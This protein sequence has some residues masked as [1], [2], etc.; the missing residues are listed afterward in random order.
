MGTD[1]GVTFVHPLHDP[2]FVSALARD[3]GSRGAGDRT[4]VM[5]RIFAGDLTDDVLERRG[6]A[7]FSVAYFRRYTREFARRWDGI[8][9]DPDMVDA[10]VLRKAWLDWIPDHRCALALQAAWLNSVER[11]VEEPIADFVDTTEIAG[12]F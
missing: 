10:E 1:A 9:F 5:R 8:G 7:N 11:G 12:S 2:R 4:S 3:L 6:K